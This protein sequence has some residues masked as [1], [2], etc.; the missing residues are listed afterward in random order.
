M[1]NAHV[2]YYFL[3]AL[4]SNGAKAAELPQYTN[5]T[6]FFI[7][8][9][10]YLLTANHVITNC[11]GK[12]YISGRF[13]INGN[14]LVAP[15]AYLGAASDSVETTIEVSVIATDVAADLALL[16][17]RPALIIENITTFRSEQNPL[18]LSET[19]I[20]V[21]YPFESVEK[22]RL[23][24]FQVQKGSIGALSAA[25]AP[26]N[27]FFASN[28]GKSLGTHG[29]SGGPVLDEAGNVIGINLAVSC[30]TPSCATSL[31]S[32]RE[33]W[34][35]TPEQSSLPP[36]KYQ[37]DLEKLLDS[38][39]IINLSAIKGFVAKNN[40]ALSF[41]PSSEIA[42]EEKLTQSAYAIANISCTAK[43][44]MEMLKSMQL[45]NP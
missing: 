44:P 17:I 18:K 23:L 12:P 28:N 37:E 1:K 9:D 22:Q 21:G 19:A 34:G 24:T 33:R 16:K 32:Y 39:M 11:G 40:V 3:F 7:T 6:A 14:Q 27:T 35:A 15:E 2:L 5:G 31:K 45:K 42:S 4:F 38:S 29:Y 25:G 20:A 13:I 8:K 10:G 26:P 30:L 36:D 43:T 41:P